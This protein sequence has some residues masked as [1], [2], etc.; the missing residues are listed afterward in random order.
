[1]AEYLVTWEMPIQASSPVD[2]ARQALGIHRDPG[3][4][5]TVFRVSIGHDSWLIDLDASYEGGVRIWG[6]E[7]KGR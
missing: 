6:I 5:A 7:R 3:S 2:A 1:M 4:V